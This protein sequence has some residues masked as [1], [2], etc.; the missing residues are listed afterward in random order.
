MARRLSPRLKAGVAWGVGGVLALA[1]G[2]P[3][4][5]LPP[6]P[7]VPPATAAVLRETAP[8]T[9]SPAGLLSQ[10]L[11]DVSENRLM[12]D[13]VALSAI[14]TRHVH[15]PGL[16]EAAAY[17]GGRFAE[18]GVAHREHTFALELRGVRTRPANIVA[19]LPGSDPAAGAIVLGAHYDSRT[20][21]IGDWTG[22]APGANDNATGV[23]VLLEVARALAGFEPRATIYLIAFAAEE[24][25]LQG[26]R[27][28][29]AESLLDPVVAMA[30]F[31]IVGNSSGSSGSGALRVFAAGPEGSPS[32]RLAR[33]TANVAARW[34]PELPVLVQDALDRP[35]RYSDHVPFTEAGIA[36][37]RFIEDG[38]HVEYQHNALDT[39][40]RIDPDY[41]RRVAQLAL[42][43]AV[44]LGIEPHAFDLE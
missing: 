26:S 18:A 12:E 29:V 23:A 10:R 22:P 36:A 6:S 21:D 15:S 43:M 20:V 44:E 37:V 19:V 5:D 30:A 24:T 33:W 11:P 9:V 3:T 41:L 2:A 17:I 40:D 27:S 16:G 34:V 35:G 1:C 32:R 31:D 13:V 7:S 39:A 42:A 25:G 28:L 4:T 8:T 38:E 14:A